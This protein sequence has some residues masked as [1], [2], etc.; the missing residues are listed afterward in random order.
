MIEYS[1]VFLRMQKQRETAVSQ[2]RWN[3]NSRKD[4]Q[5]IK[6]KKKIEKKIENWKKK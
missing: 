3:G 6:I 5:C 4:L 1:F 2:V